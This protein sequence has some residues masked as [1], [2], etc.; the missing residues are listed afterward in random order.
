MLCNYV[1]RMRAPGFPEC[2]CVQPARSII[3]GISDF[4]VLFCVLGKFYWVTY[5]IKKGFKYS[6]GTFGCLDWF[7]ELIFAY[8]HEC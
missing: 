6:T 3:L 8:P 5:T 4:L 1:G 2:P 7:W